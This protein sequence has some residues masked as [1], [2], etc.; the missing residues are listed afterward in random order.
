MNSMYPFLRPINFCVQNYL[1]SPSSSLLHY[2]YLQFFLLLSLFFPFFLL[3]LSVFL[4]QARP[5]GPKDQTDNPRFESSQDHLFGPSGR[6]VSRR[7]IRSGRIEHNSFSV[8]PKKK[9]RQGAE[10]YFCSL[11]SPLFPH[12]KFFIQFLFLIL[13]S[14]LSFLIFFLNFLSSY[15]LYSLT[16]TIFLLPFVSFSNWILKNRFILPLS[17]ISLP[18]F[19][20]SYTVPLQ[21]LPSLILSQIG[22]TFSPPFL[23]PVLKNKSPVN[24]F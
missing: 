18:L 17:S 6:I 4:S 11:S 2:Y 3:F 5:S 14:L 23:A 8:E 19:L 22:I 13:I 15:M 10:H 9:R 1:L 20:L 16:M 7:G 12:T 21:F 24:L